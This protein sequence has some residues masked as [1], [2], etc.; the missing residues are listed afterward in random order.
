[1]PPIVAADYPVGRFRAR[2]ITRAGVAP[3]GGLNFDHAIDTPGT[4]GVL[5][6]ITP[7]SIV[8]DVNQTP[9][10]AWDAAGNNALFAA[11][12]NNQWA[13]RGF[14]FLFRCRTRFN[15]VDAMRVE[16]EIEFHVERPGTIYTFDVLLKRQ[17]YANAYLASATDAVGLAVAVFRDGGGLPVAQ[18]F[19]DWTRST[20]F[21][22]LETFPEVD[23][24]PQQFRLMDRFIIFDDEELGW[25]DGWATLRRFGMNVQ[26]V[27]PRENLYPALDPALYGD[28]IAHGTFRPAGDSVLPY[29]L[30]SSPTFYTD[31][32]ANNAS[33]PTLAGVA[34]RFR[35]FAISDEPHWYFTAEFNDLLA[36]PTGLARYREFLQEQAPGGVPL[37]P[38]D[39]GFATWADVL[40]ENRSALCDTNLTNRRNWYWTARFL[41]YDSSLHHARSA[42]AL[43]PYFPNAAV[44]TN[45]NNYVCRWI[46]PGPSG[47][48]PSPPADLRAAMEHDYWEFARLGGGTATVKSD[49]FGDGD[50]FKWF[51]MAEQVAGVERRSGV[52]WI[53]YPIGVSTGSVRWGV[54]TKVFA[55]V[56]CGAKSLYYYLFGPEI[57]FPGSCYS[58]RLDPGT[59]L[60][61][62]PPVLARLGEVHQVLADYEDVLFPGVAP[63][64]R[65]A[66]LQP[67]SCQAHDY[68]PYTLTGLEGGGSF[69]LVIRDITNSEP[70]FF[71]AP[72]SAELYNLFFALLHQ[73]IPAEIIE[74]DELCAGCLDQY[75]VVYIT[76]E[77]IP[78]EG[79]EALVEWVR[80][81]G[82][83]VR[84]TLAGQRDRYSEPDYTLTDAIGVREADRA[85]AVVESAYGGTTNGDVDDG[86]SA[87]QSAWWG[88]GTLTAENGEVLATWDDD[89]SPAILKT[90]LGQGHVWS[91]L[92]YPGISYAH[93]QTGFTGE[94]RTGH[95]AVLREWIKWPVDAAAIAFSVSLVTERLNWRV[96]ENEESWAVFLFNMIGA[97]VAAE[98]VVI[99][100]PFVVAS[101]ERVG[102]G[103][104]TFEQNGAGPV[105]LTTPVT[106]TELFILTAEAGTGEGRK[107]VRAGRGMA[108][109]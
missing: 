103:P 14:P 41:S 9:W 62:S 39:L 101:I 18:K 8:T 58:D 99:R 88:R 42:Q 27:P 23:P 56:S 34:D 71:A 90:R 81:G 59:G 49:W 26:T 61:L 38:A 67:R 46:S 83:L 68:R 1:M 64:S 19:S 3:T 25:R 82:H 76:A 29:G 107:P 109:R 5:N 79:Q 10:L 11:H 93:S 50:F 35:W 66:V 24:K 84:T 36:S 69:P 52:P 30:D 86:V 2:V 22:T 78:T 65:V 106:E 51:W 94:I 20:Y 47:P 104:V 53:A 55:A 48:N 31:W 100:P 72:W 12:P 4:Q 80:A 57:L 97:N 37:T 95:S 6:P 74:E 45:W 75:R 102:S 92:F 43:A 40:P 32:A 15:I 28:G 98:P 105:F 54:K 17:I 87:V 89:G 7:T 33:G 44:I 63:R 108:R 73:G 13:S 60:P 16:Y 21:V 85:K 70:N 77:E 91:Y 96:L